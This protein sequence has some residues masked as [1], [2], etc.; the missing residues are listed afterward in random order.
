MNENI[1]KNLVELDSGI[2]FEIL[3]KIFEEKNIEIINNF[4]LNKDNVQKKIK[5]INEQNYKYPYKDLS[6]LNIFN[7]IMEQGK[8]LKNSPKIEL[9]FN[10]FI[11]KSFSNIPIPENLIIDSIIYVLNNYS[12]VNKVIVENKIK[13]LIVIFKKILNNKIFTESDYKKI[14][15]HINDHIFDEVKAFIHKKMSNTK[16]D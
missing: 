15:V 16:T 2:Y 7:Y 4:N 8:K 10:L 9:D 1:M 13:K 6:P 11:I 14:L 3:N 12:L 5:N